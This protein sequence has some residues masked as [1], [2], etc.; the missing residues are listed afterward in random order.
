METMQAVAK[1][2]LTGL[3]T[4]ALIRLL[5]KDDG[6]SSSVVSC[7]VSAV[8]SERLKARLAV[9]R[10]LL[11]RELREKMQTELTVSQPSHLTDWLR[12]HFKEHEQEAFLVLALNA[13]HGLIEAQELFQGTTN[14]CHVYPREV[15][16]F[17]LMN[18]ACSL[19]VAHNHPSGS[20]QPSVNDRH[21]TAQLVTALGFVD[22]RLLDHFIVSGSAV[23]SMAEEGLM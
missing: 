13:Q 2:A 12:L 16:R 15:V 20:T 21:L 5:F 17:A 11:M 10:E 3:P 19:I 8:Y 18:R 6:P 1:L 22:V 7:D 4:A 14:S 9:A 23:L